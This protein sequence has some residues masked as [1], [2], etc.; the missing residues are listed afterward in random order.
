V[1]VLSKNSG[2]MIFLKDRPQLSDTSGKL[3]AFSTIT[4]GFSL[5]Q[6]TTVLI[7]FTIKMENKFKRQNN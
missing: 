4:C 3:T 5:A 2:L 6:Y 1:T 7:Y